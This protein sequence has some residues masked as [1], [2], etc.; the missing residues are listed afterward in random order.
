M[1]NVQGLYY[2]FGQLAYAVAASDGAIQQAEKDALHD[3]LVKKTNGHGLD[4]N[5]AEIIFQLLGRDHTKVETAYE[6]ALKQMKLNE[7][8]L[9]ERR[10]KD[11]VE[12]LEKIA[13]A[14]APVTIG[15]KSIINKFREDIAL[16]KADPAFTGEK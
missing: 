16:L 12:I 3:L 8:Y 11:F 14:K 15:E 9:T 6:W 1:D 2:A 10:K 4:F 7:Y 5:Y 13:E